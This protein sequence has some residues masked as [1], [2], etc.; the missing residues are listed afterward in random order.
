MTWVQKRR[1]EKI[2]RAVWQKP[3]F[4]TFSEERFMWWRTESAAREWMQQFGGY[5]EAIP[6]TA[7]DADVWA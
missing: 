5:Y 6:D 1:L 4:V 2:E 7:E 3:R